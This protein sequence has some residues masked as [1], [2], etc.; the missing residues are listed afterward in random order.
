M[1]ARSPSRSLNGASRA[2]VIGIAVALSACDAR[3]PPSPPETKLPPAQV[4]EASFYAREL[5][6]QPTASGEPLR[7]DGLTAASNSLPLGTAAK[8]TSAE[9][10][11][12]VTVRVN[13]R[14]PFAKGRILDVSP[15]AAE[16]LGMEAD[17]VA[18]V[19]VQ[20]LAPPP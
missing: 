19:V 8:V 20:P 15:K 14:G 13:D 4:G 6:G 5:V 18:D 1:R 11:R 7:A 12:S 2:A 16:H 9:T 17:G 10:G 3:Q